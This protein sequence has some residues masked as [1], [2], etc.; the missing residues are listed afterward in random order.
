MHINSY[1]KFLSSCLE[2]SE[3]LILPNAQTDRESRK[4]ASKQSS[5]LDLIYSTF[6]ESLPARYPLKAIYKLQLAL[7]FCNCWTKSNW[8]IKCKAHSKWSVSCNLIVAVIYCFPWSENVQFTGVTGAL[9]GHI[10]LKLSSMS[11]KQWHEWTHSGTLSP[12]EQLPIGNLNK[13]N[14]HKD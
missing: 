4:R 13:A 5:H 6:S 14:T 2:G 12:G 11:I 9:F 3:N 1:S 8:K 10:S 7:V